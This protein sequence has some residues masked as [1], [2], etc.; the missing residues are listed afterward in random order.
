MSSFRESSEKLARS[1]KTTLIYLIAAF[2]LGGFIG[3]TTKNELLLS[4]FLILFMLILFA[5]LESEHAFPKLFQPK[6]D[7]KSS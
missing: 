3:D 4:L 1:W 6:S 7:D 5:C 2:T